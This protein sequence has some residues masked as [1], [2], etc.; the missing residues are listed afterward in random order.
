MSTRVATDYDLP[1]LFPFG[2]SLVA[3]GD[4]A[5]TDPSPRVGCA[6]PV[7]VASSLDGGGGGNRTLVLSRPTSGFQLRLSSHPL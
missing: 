1:C 5:I 6:A 4:S 3:S 7:L 2:Q